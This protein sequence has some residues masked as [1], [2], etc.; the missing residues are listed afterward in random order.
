MFKKILVI[1]L[2]IVL[3]LLPFWPITEHFFPVVNN[4]NFLSYCLTCTGIFL[5][6]ATVAI[7]LHKYT[8][9]VTAD[10]KL[11]AVSCLFFVAGFPAMFAL[12][13]G[14]PALGPELLTLKGIEQVR[15]S[16]LLLSLILFA[17]GC[18]MLLQAIAVKTALHAYLFTGFLT[19]VTL[20]NCWDNIS[21]LTLGSQ[22]TSWVAAG[23]NPVDYFIH[24]DHHIY[25][26]FFARVSLYVIAIWMSILLLKAGM[27]KR[28]QALL[29]SLFCCTGIGFCILF[30]IKG[31]EYYFPFMIPAIV[32]APL[33]WTGI[34]LL[35]K[36]GDTSKQ[37]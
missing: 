31:F 26:R 33:Y 37:Q 35:S 30:I 23:K 1:L 25:W 21:S 27:L 8:T 28:W 24:L 6:A 22:L 18:F 15:Y 32:L 11:L 10:K 17:A 4:A 36:P 16:M 9:A 20:L 14:A 19:I 12:H 29:L 3:M 2:C 7:C 34:A 5:V 13:L